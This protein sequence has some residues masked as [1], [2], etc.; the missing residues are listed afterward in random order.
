MIGKQVLSSMH[1]DQK[2]GLGFMVGLPMDKAFESFKV[3]FDTL[4]R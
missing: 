3:F 1:I 2:L 4:V